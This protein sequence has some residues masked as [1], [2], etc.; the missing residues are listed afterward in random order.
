MKRLTLIGTKEFS[1]Q[2]IS[3]AN[4]TGE[5]EFVGFFDDLVE[6]G[7]IINGK[8]VLGKVE[9]AIK[10][11]KQGVF[12]CIFEGIGYTRFDLREFYYNILKGKV[13]FANIIDPTA[14]LGRDVKLGEGIYV[15]RNAI[16][17]DETIIEDN[18]FIHRNNMV[19]HNSIVHKHSY[20]SGLDHMAGFCEIGSRSFIG[21]SV[22]VAD[23]VKISDDVWVGIGCVVAKNLK[24]PGKY[25]TDSMILTRLDWDDSSRIKSINPKNQ[26]G[27]GVNYPH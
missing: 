14:E 7:T 20:L 11:Y 12:D 6:K 4:R 13:P 26:P 16:I 24:K 10:L 21:L 3:F 1:E 15:G 17:D 19:G 18:V 9:E 22:C 5:Y 25:L 2:I 27:G 8:P 23:H